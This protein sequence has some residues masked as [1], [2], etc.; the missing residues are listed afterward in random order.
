MYVERLESLLTGAAAEAVANFSSLAEEAYSATEYYATTSAA[1][2]T[3]SGENK[4]VGTSSIPV[5]RSTASESEG[6]MGRGEPLVGSGGDGDTYH[7]GRVEVMGQQE[8]EEEEEDHAVR[9][10]HELSL[11]EVLSSPY[12]ATFSPQAIHGGD[13]P[14]SDHRHHAHP[15]DHDDHHHHLTAPMPLPL[16]PHT[17]HSS[18]MGTNH[19]TVYPPAFEDSST[20][21]NNINRA[22]N[23]DAPGG[24]NSNLV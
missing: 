8:E 3:A 24:D 10:V 15:M 5:A 13:E 1:T 2:V 6:T 4:A 17:Y 19:H 22:L 7:V 20:G 18:S 16:P 12:A 21:Y 11:A 23:Y 9:E 14:S